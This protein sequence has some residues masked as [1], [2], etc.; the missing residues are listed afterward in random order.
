[1][2]EGVVA[3][4]ALVPW[5]LAPTVAVTLAVAVLAGPVW[6]AADGAIHPRRREE[7][8]PVLAYVRDHWRPGDT[9]YLHYGAQ[10]A[11]L[12]YSECDCFRT[13]GRGGKRLW[14]AKRA[15]AGPAQFAPAVRP[16]SEDLLVGPYAGGDR[17]R[18]L[19]DLDRLRKR[20]R[21]WF[22]YTHVN[23]DQEASFIRQRLLGRLGDMGRLL[24]SISRA[25]AH[26]YL[27]RFGPSGR[28]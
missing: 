12:Y 19:A 4:A 17:T 5:R 21:V 3:L 14:P 6:T 18:Q 16:L 26:A 22:V 15:P 8:K 11:F 23:D 2:A 13:T 10:Y 20:T 24:E 27:Y 9:L 7:I 28:G 25:G 1:V